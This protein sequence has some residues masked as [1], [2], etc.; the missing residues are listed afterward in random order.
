MTS[1][2]AKR[3]SLHKNLVHQQQEND[4]LKCQIGQLQAL[5][6]IGTVSCMIAH[7]VNNLLTPLANYAALALNN[8]D[9]KTLIE[10]ALRKAV[11]NCEHA[12]RVMESM[13]AVVNGE[14]REKKEIR[15]KTALL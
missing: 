4:T 12:S 10:K 8:L 5:A 11:Q 2:I 14:T 13:L 9:D 6:N 15:L 7:E 1:I 3:R